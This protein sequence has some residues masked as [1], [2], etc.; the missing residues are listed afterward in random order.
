AFKEEELTGEFFV[1]IMKDDKILKEN[2]KVV[3]K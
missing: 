3:L 2:K 1:T